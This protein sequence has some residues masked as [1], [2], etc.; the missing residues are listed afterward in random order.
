MCGTNQANG[1][2]INQISKAANYIDLFADANCI[3]YLSH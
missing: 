3:T 1:M 2:D